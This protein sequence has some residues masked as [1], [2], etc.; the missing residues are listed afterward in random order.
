[1]GDSEK[2]MVGEEV[3]AIGNPFGLDQTLTRGIVSAVNRLLP[4]ASMS[5]TEPLIQTDAAINPGSSGGPLMNRCGEVVGITTAL[6]PGAQSIG[7]AIPSNLIKTVAPTIISKGRLVRPW[8]GVQGQFVVPALKELL[9]VP[10]VDGFLVE[11]V[12]PD[13]PAEN[14]GIEGGDLDLTISGQSVLIGGDIITEVNGTKIDD[15]AKLG[16]TLA[17][18]NI[19]DKIR[20]TFVR[21]KKTMNVEITLVERPILPGDIPAR[22]GMAPAGADA[23]V[24]RQSPFLSPR[25]AF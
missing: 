14:A 15:P 10:L 17:P 25:R 6:L 3:Y 1:M 19:G 20:M 5:L 11:V 4:G 23:S 8:F 21:D 22:R 2:L 12:E 24:N 9:R 16:Q 18:L 13:S 7:F